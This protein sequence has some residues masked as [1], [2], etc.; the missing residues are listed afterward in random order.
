MRGLALIL[1]S[2]WLAAAPAM[3]RAN[4]DDANIA[5]GDPALRYPRAL[6]QDIVEDHFG[7][8]IGRAH[9]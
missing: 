8:Q 3:L 5:A 7:V 4:P 2:L 1:L 6:R 9:V